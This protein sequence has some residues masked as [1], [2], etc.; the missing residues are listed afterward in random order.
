MYKRQLDEVSILRA[1][2]DDGVGC[3]RF[4]HRAGIATLGAGELLDLI[5]FGARL[6]GL[7]PRLD[8][9]VVEVGDLLVVDGDAL[10]HRQVVLGAE[11]LDSL[12]GRQHARLE[13]V[14]L[15]V[16]PGRGGLGGVVLGEHLLREIFVGDG[17]GDGRRL[18]R[19]PRAG[20]DVDQEGGLLA[21]HLQAL[22][23]ALDRPGLEDVVGADAR[24]R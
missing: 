6:R 24:R 18:D 23:Q 13:R 17:I 8:Q 15:L 7:H 1:Q 16:H 20:I 10:R 22:R 21:R 3:E 14:E 19:L 11:V 9:L 4:R 2:A 12:V 5:I